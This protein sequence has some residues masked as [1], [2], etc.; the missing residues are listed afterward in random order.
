MD[1]VS[2]RTTIDDIARENTIGRF[3]SELEYLLLCK[4]A[5]ESVKSKLSDT[6]DSSDTDNLKRINDLR[7]I[8]KQLR[9][10]NDE[11]SKKAREDLDKLCVKLREQQYKKVWHRLLPEQ[12]KDQIE[13]FFKETIEDETERNN[14]IDKVMHMLE[15]GKL[16]QK[17]INYNKHA[18]KIVEINYEK[19]ETDKKT[20]G[21]KEQIKKKESS[22]DS[23]N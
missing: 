10:K 1:T 13:K 3:A 21:K 8:L 11:K 22:S 18:G 2:F 19:E 12:K 6:S 9:N 15:D 5:K 17:M 16:K 20:K 7:E 14:K 4:K 23:D